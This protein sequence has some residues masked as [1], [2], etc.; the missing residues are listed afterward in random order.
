MRTTGDLEDVQ[1]W[2][3][4]VSVHARASLDKQARI[5]DL[6]KLLENPSKMEETAKMRIEA[7]IEDL[8]AAREASIEQSRA[9]REAGRFLQGLLR[10]GYT[11]FKEKASLAEI[12]QSLERDI[13][14]GRWPPVVEEA[15]PYAS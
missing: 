4:F 1:S 9:Y 5:D 7:S 15:V 14:T 6:E 12:V 3:I 2:M 8:R 11:P 10:T 13:S